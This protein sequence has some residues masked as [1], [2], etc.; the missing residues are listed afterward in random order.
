MLPHQFPILWYSLFPSRSILKSNLTGWCTVYC[1]NNELPVRVPGWS[2]QN[3]CQSIAKVALHDCLVERN[4]PS[5]I[6]AAMN[7]FD[8]ACAGTNA[9]G[10]LTGARSAPLSTFTPTSTNGAIQTVV[11]QV[12]PGGSTTIGTATTGNAKNGAKAVEWCFGLI[13]VSIFI[14]WI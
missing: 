10:I 2:P 5:E 3:G 4:C 11:V 8:V 9:Q 13:L 7:A 6:D 14:S 1:L 12:Q